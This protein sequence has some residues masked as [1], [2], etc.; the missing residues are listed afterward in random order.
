MIILSIPMTF[1]FIN[2]ITSII[3]QRRMVTLMYL[4]TVTGGKNW[5]YFKNHGEKILRKAKNAKYYYGVLDI[6]MEKYRNYCVCHGVKNAEDVLETIYNTIDKTMQHGEICARYANSDFVVMIRCDYEQQCEEKAR[7][8]IDT[9]VVSI[10]GQ[11]MN[12]HV[13]MYIV[14]PGINQQVKKSIRRRSID[15]AEIYNYACS[16]RASL[17]KQEGNGFARFNRI[18]LDDQ[19]WEHKVEDMME[20]ALINEEFEVYLQPKY[21]PAE[22]ELVGAEALVRWVNPTEGFISPGRFISIFENN[23]FILIL[24]DYMISHVAKIVF[25]WIADGKELV[26]IS[27]NVSRAHFTQPDL[28]EHINEIVDTYNIPHEFIELELTESAFFDDKK[29]LLETVKKLKSYGFTVSMDDFGSGY[30]SLNSLKDLPLDV[31][32]LDA[33]FFRGEDDEQRGEIVVSEA[34]QLA[35]SL[36]MKVVAEGIE[37]KEQVD[38]LSTLECD[39]IQGFYFAKPMPVSEFENL[40]KFRKS[41]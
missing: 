14:E 37:K 31:L 2:V 32:K 13:G 15:L 18:M 25:E 35:K 36:N 11:R 24:D 27:V 8:L 19:L 16:A 30:S 9:I 5:L 20:Q 22:A 10:P 23:G 21:S 39:M 26:P 29:M 17:A 6:Q 1:L 40:E 12:F 3:T 38:F 28:A 41:C 33:E 34:I 7:A 4:D